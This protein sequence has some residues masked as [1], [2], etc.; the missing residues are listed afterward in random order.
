[1][2]KKGQYWCAI[3]TKIIRTEMV[4]RNVTYE[5]LSQR[6][7]QSGVEMNASNLRVRISNGTFSAALLI[8]CMRAMGIKNLAIDDSYFQEV[9]I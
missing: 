1:M 8:Q 2:N 4:K 9:Q 5:N 6:L 7:R 3:T